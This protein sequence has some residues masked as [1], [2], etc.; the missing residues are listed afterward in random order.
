[1]LGSDQAH[2]LSPPLFSRSAP[3]ALCWQQCWPQT[4]CQ[5]TSWNASSSHW[6]HPE[7]RAEPPRSDD[8]CIRTSLS[9]GDRFCPPAISPSRADGRATISSPTPAPPMPERHRKVTTDKTFAD[10]G[11]RRPIVSALAAR[12]IT[13][14]FPIQ[15][16]T[17]PDTLAGRDVLGR[18]EDRQRKNAGLLDSAGQPALRTKPAS[19][20]TIGF[21]A[22]AHP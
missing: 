11:V 3:G 21:G 13:H 14:P 9:R 1:M 12:G 18:G 20:A 22:R 17:L 8:P 10:L 2:T 4:R 16:A 15:V 7:L 6:C 19:V 5:H